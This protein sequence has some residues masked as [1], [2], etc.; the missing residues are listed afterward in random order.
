M[1]DGWNLCLNFY[2]YTFFIPNRW[3]ISSGN[4]TTTISIIA[5]VVVMVVVVVGGD[6]GIC[7]SNNKSEPKWH[8]SHY[9]QV[10]M[11]MWELQIGEHCMMISDTWY[12]LD[13]DNHPGW[14]IN[15]NV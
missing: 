13:Y 14:Y 15:G 10:M 4:S 8:F 7:S 1:I 5:I 9:I 12:Y 2:Y 6:E 11:G 3:Y